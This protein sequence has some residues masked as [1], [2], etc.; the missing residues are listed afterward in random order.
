MDPEPQ[1]AS[2]GSVRRIPRQGRQD[3]NS[4]S[5]LIPDFLSVHES[6]A[7]QTGQSDLLAKGLQSFPWIT[8]RRCVKKKK[9]VSILRAR[10]SK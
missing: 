9:I 7:L 1:A 4:L 2:R 6:Q 8:I 3:H 5:R 10:S